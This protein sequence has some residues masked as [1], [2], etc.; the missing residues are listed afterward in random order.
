MSRLQQAFRDFG[1]GPGDRVAALL[2]NLPET[3]AAMLA[4]ASI[5]AVWSSA[6]PDFG[7]RGALDRFGQIAPKLFIACDG[8]Y[9]AGKAIDIAGKVAEIAAGLP[10]AAAVI[11]VPY[12]DRADEV[13]AE[14][15]RAVTLSAALAPYR[16]EPLRFEQFPFGH[17]LFILF[18]SG[19]TGVPKC[20]V[21]SA[22]G[23]LL[24]HIKE[25]R[26]H[27]GLRSGERLFYF[28]TCGWMMW[29]WLATGL[30]TGATLMLYDGSP[31]HPSPA[32][33][34]DFAEAERFDI[35]RHL[36]EVHRR[37]RQVGLRA[38]RPSRPVERQDDLLHRVAARRRQL[39]LR[40]PR[41]SG[42]TC[43]S[44]RFPAAP[45]SSPASCSAFRRSRSGVARSRDLGSAWRSTCGARTEPR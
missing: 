38:G 7:A 41:R 36:G 28:T 29:N 34:F 16:A 21:H 30:A 32:V 25:H 17:P 11:V 31:F 6:S 8:Y 45:T 12:L 24:Q 15:P 39:R 44:P 42:R 14:L 4:T 43:I 35:L 5:G 26:L 27:C 23:T 22:G 20:I 1:V 18:S 3:I 13:A 19:T 10:T 40:L 2:P 33:L 37:S 9:Y